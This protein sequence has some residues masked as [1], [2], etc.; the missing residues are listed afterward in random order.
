MVLDGRCFLKIPLG[1]SLFSLLSLLVRIFVSFLGCRLS[2]FCE[3]P[4]VVV[5]SAMLALSDMDE[6][7]SLDGWLIICGGTGGGTVGP[8][9]GFMEP[10]EALFGMSVRMTG[11]LD[12][13]GDGTVR[14]VDSLRTPE[15]SETGEPFRGGLGVKPWTVVYVSNFRLSRSALTGL[16]K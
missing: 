14:S 2:S 3:L 15:A 16:A 4:I 6:N 9:K 8:V 1:F 7:A 5:V 10:E 12:G 13:I 11:L